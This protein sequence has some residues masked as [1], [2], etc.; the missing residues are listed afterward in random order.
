MAA[1][2][3]GATGLLPPTSLILSGKLCFLLS[4][5]AFMK[6]TQAY[7]AKVPPIVA[8]ALVA[9]SPYAIYGS[10]GYTEPLFLL[11]T[12]LSFYLWKT[13]RYVAS[14][15]GG[16][17][18]SGV[19][20][21]GGFFALSLLVGGFRERLWGAEAARSRFL[22]GLFLA[23][24][25]VALF[26]TYLYFWMGDALSFVHVMKAWGR[27]PGNPLSHLLAYLQGD[28]LA[29]LWAVMVLLAFAL[30]GR[31]IRDRRYELAAFSLPA[32]LLPLST[33]LVSMPRYLWWQAPLLLALAET[34]RETKLW[35]LYV[36]IAVLGL[37]W[38]YHAWM[39]GKS[40][41]I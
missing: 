16:A 6:F 35:P 1:G 38:M 2:I 13:K 21:V 9:F 10:T 11:L 40:F 27:I 24:L 36:P 26:M 37:T 14:G 15:L 41:V 3:H 20:L 30:I 29:R 7:G 4:I 32:T 17:G 34:L 5:F 25:G 39:A 19:R 8:G 22:L 23:P 12:C 33:G 28:G 18:L 31:L